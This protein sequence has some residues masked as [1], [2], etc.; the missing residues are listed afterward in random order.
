VTS[1]GPAVYGL[2][3][4]SGHMVQHMLLAMVVPIFL[5]LGAPV[6]LALR[7]LPARTDGSHG[8]RE[9]LLALVHSRWAQ[10]W[11]RPVVAAINFAG[12]MIVFYY[13]IG[14]ASC[15]ERVVS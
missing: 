11:A 5:V 6:T 7:A 13:K 8:P 12:S 15:R 9:W 14:R 10:F 1:G 4:F 3:L 2:V